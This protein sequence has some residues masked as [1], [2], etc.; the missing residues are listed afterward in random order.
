M[1][2][3]KLHVMN[4]AFE[5]VQNMYAELIEDHN[6]RAYC[7]HHPEYVK[8]LWNANWHLV[9]T[10]R[11]PTYEEYLTAWKHLLYGKGEEC[12][13]FEGTEISH[14]RFMIIPRRRENK[15]YWVV[16]RLRGRNPDIKWHSFRMAEH[17][18]FEPVERVDGVF[19]TNFQAYSYAASIQN[20]ENEAAIQELINLTLMQKNQ[21]IFVKDFM[22][23]VYNDEQVSDEEL[24]I[25][26]K[27]ADDYRCRYYQLHVPVCYEDVKQIVLE[28]IGEFMINLKE[29]KPTAIFVDR[30]AV[31]NE[32]IKKV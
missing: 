13:T 32:I 11:V 14:Y 27:T 26:F 16:K 9:T 28:F 5:R 29:T 17:D 19:S 4:E 15:Q 8:S 10:D 31:Y 6:L 12:E 22:K 24:K 21:A 2:K 20:T 25:A 18:P 23:F 3:Y 7:R 30:N 1:E